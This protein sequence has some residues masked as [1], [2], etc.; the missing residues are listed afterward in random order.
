MPYMLRLTGDGVAIHDSKVEWGYAT[1]G[2]IGVPVAF[3]K[4]LFGVMGRARC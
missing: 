1:H 3:A 4:A 2:C